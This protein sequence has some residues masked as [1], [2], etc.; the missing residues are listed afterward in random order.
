M[1][2]TDKPA[3]SDATEKAQR[4]EADKHAAPVCERCRVQFAVCGCE[5]P[6]ERRR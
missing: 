5:P 2:S 3:S 4:A 1:L 6:K